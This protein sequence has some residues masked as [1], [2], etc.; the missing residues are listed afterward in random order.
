MKQFKLFVL[1][2]VFTT[3]IFNPYLLFA[4]TAASKWYDNI[5]LEGDARLRWEDIYK[6]P[7][8]DNER[9]RFRTRLGLSS[10]ISENIELFFRFETGIKDPVSSNQTIGESGLGKEIGVGRIYA[11]WKVN[12]KL[13]I[14]GGKMKMPWFTAGGNTLLWDRDLNP[15]GIFSSYENADTFFNIAHIIIDQNPERNDTT[16]QSF[17]A[18]K[19]FSLNNTTSM[20]AGFGYH[21]YKK[22]NGGLPFY[23]AKGNSLDSDG[24]YL[25]D[26]KL[27]EFFSEIKTELA[28]LPVT[29]HLEII[30]NSAVINENKAYSLG[31]RVGPLKKRGDKQFSYTYQD[32]EKDAVLGS[33]SD[34]DFAGGN[35]DSKGHSI[36]TRYKL[37]DNMT[38]SGIFIMSDYKPSKMELI[39][40]NRTQIDLEFKF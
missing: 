2:A 5:S 20:I 3:S 11:N 38:L 29:M 23:K 28:Q 15:E 13:Q 39:D 25:F 18:A 24:N 21:G 1:I 37:S 10:A 33:F 16:L 17:Q 35:T 34:S 31:I 36:I 32:T 4:Q 7:G 27:Y 14:M 40:Y 19:K 6:N 22:A 26:Y 12:D 8:N 9:E 30:S